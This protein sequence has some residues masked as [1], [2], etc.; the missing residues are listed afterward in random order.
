MEYSKGFPTSHNTQNSNTFSIYYDIIIFLSNEGMLST[1][2]M[3]AKSTQNYQNLPKRQ[4]LE[5]I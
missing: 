1:I 2:A 5:E 3:A 4:Q